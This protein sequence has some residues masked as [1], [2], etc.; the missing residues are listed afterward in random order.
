VNLLVI[1]TRGSPLAL[2]QTQ[3]IIDR[4]KQE[5]P[6]L[7]IKTKIIK[8]TG[9]QL[10]DYE[11]LEAIQQ[12]GI[13][14]KEIEKKL[15][16]AEIDLAVHSLKD[17]PVEMPQGLEIAAIPPREDPRDCWVSLH[18]P[19][20]DCLEPGAIVAVGSPRR[21]NQLLR[22]RPD[23]RVVPIRGNVETRLKKLRENKEWMG[24][25]LAMAGIKR[26]GID[27]S[28][29]FC[30]YL[31]L[32]WMLPAPG[33]GALALETRQGDKRTQ[34]LVQFLND[35]PSACEVCAE[36]SFLYEL[37]GGC[38]TAVGAMAKVERS[39]LVL[40]GIWWPQGSL[41]P[42]EGKVVGQI[43]EAKKL[44]QELAHLLRKL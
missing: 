12:R 26:L 25:I 36:R 8:T 10:S 32:D 21:A 9:D 20:P 6:D 24:T 22:K 3:S 28:S 7:E 13:F 18:Y 30:T 4:L 14:T 39:K 16:E 29:F 23:L 2:I 19:H 5:Y 1:G 38:R 31:G 11:H 40:Y 17:M 34:D 37:G 44:G 41:R 15:L 27:L 33:Q 35:F 42:K 43:Q